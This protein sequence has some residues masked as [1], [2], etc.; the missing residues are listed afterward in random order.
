MR[1]GVLA[2]A[3]LVALVGCATVSDAGYYWG[4]YSETYYQWVVAPSEETLAAHVA[5]LQDIITESKERELRVPPGIY[6]ELAFFLQRQGGAD[7]A[8][9]FYAQEIELYPESAVML[10]RLQQ[11]ENGQ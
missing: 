3:L 11:M 8:P 1:N 6:A 5:E 10:Q 4:E 7:S 2:I 9:G